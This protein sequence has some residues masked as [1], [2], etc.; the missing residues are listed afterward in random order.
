VRS[1]ATASGPRRRVR[2]VRPVRGFMR[3]LALRAAP[4]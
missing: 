1:G 4:V 3:F 2:F